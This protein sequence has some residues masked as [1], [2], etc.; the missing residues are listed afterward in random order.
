MQKRVKLIMECIDTIMPHV[1]AIHEKYCDCHED[2][3]DHQESLCA[4]MLFNIA[5]EYK[6]G[7]LNLRQLE[8]AVESYIDGEYAIEDGRDN[9]EV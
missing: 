6:L 8:E 7:N 2:S 9:E 3:R 5:L 1:E 4:T